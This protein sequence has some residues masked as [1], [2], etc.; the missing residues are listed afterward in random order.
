MQILKKASVP[1]IESIL[2]KVQLH[3]AGH[4]SRMENTC[5][6]NA[7][8]SRE[9]QEGKRDRGAQRK[10]YKDRLKRQLAQAGNSHQTWQQEASD[11]NS[12]CSS[13]RK[14]DR[15]FKAKRHE[16]AKKRC[17]SQKECAA[18]QSSSAQSFACPKCRR[19]CT[20]RIRLSSHQ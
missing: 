19:V 12:W 17:W 11:R 10:C 6:P 15:K 7:V 5:M 9:L 18:S 8:F 2:F 3:W 13:V 4:V 14:A 1:S 16:A 20:S